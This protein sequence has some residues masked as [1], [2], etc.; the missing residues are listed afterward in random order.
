MTLRYAA[1]ANRHLNVHSRSGEEWQCLC[2]Y[3]EDT[4]PSFSLNVRKGLFICY[5]C[6]AKGTVD[7]L[8]DHLSAD[9]PEGEEISVSDV[10]DKIAR[11][12]QNL[13]R[14]RFLPP[15][16]PKAYQLGN[17]REMW[18]ERGITSDTVFDLFSLGYDVLEDELIIPVHAPDSRRLVSYIRRRRNPEPHQPKYLYQKNFKISENLFGSW[19]ARTVE[20]MAGVPAIAVTEGSIDTLAL[21]QA[22]VP[23]VALLGARCSPAQAKLIRALSPVF[24]VAM[25]DHDTAGKQAEEQ[26][27]SILHGTGIRVVIPTYWPLGCKDPADMTDDQRYRSFMSAL[28]G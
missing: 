26:L 5:A 25:T 22:G 21:W 24:L 13:P 3:H 11:L 18:T 1:F 19:Q 17:Y 8:A 2:P 20:P 12:H 23:S 6:G 10:R 28:D 15:D 27:E 7:S 9:R 4:S 14:R 16:M